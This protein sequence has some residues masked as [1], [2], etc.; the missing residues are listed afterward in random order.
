M[1]V[2]T[3]P[4]AAP[5]REAA[6]VVLVR[7]GPVGIEVFMLRRSHRLVFT[8]G[9][10]VFPGGALDAADRDPA[11]AACCVG[12]DDAEAS[13]VLAVAD[14]GLAFW[15]AAVRECFEE[16]GVLLARDREDRS[17]GL[18]DPLT[19][20]RF[21]RHRDHLNAGRRTIAEICTGESVRLDVAPI[22]YFAHWLTPHPSPRRYNTRFFVVEVPA[23]QRPL[24]DDGEAVEGLWVR[25]EDALARWPGEAELIR[26]T[27]ECLT[28]FTRF[29]T[30][31][32]LLGAVATMGRVP[33]AQPRMGPDGD[34]VRVLLPGDD[35]W[36]AAAAAA[37]GID[38]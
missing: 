7:D 5:I 12:R 37:G 10:Y 20:A 3:H 14:G 21:R 28:A 23:D 27:R 24:H 4:G 32:E 36:A 33:D 29:A 15:V 31:G 16:A 17:L 1:V 19:A 13:R 9:A 18:G 6:T 38:A 35:G 26:P 34:G 22:H 8:P 2:A 11:A 30:A 25:P